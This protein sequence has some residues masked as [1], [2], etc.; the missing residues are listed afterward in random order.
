MSIL[1]CIVMSCI[2]MSQ[3]VVRDLDLQAMA[4]PVDFWYHA[5]IGYQSHLGHSLK[6]IH[7]FVSSLLL[8]PLCA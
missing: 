7:S 6:A 3:L 2:P 4:R 1:H 5:Y 8:I